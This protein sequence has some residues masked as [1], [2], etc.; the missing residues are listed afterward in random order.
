MRE[1]QGYIAGIYGAFYMVYI[2]ELWEEE[3]REESL[4]RAKVRGKLRISYQVAYKV[5]EKFFKEHLLAVGDQIKVQLLVSSHEEEKEIEG[6]I[7]YLFPRKNVF[8]RC[9]QTKIQNIAADIDRVLVLGCIRNPVFSLGFLDR[10]LVDAEAIGVEVGILVN[11]MDL[12]QEEEEEKE[13]LRKLSYYEKIGYPVFYE[14]VLYEVSS[15]LRSFLEKGVTLFVGQ[16]GVGKST[17]LNSLVGKSIQATQEVSSHGKGRHTTTNPILYPYSKEAL[18]ID[19]PGVREFGLM[20]REKEE[21]A[22]YFRDFPEGSCKY[23]DC[24]HQEEPGCLVKEK[25]EKGEIPSWRYHSY[26]DI[27]QSLEEKFKPRRGDYWHNLR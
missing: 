27:L 17:L 23:R 14:K 2:P 19:V 6:Y 22:R 18:F 26:I 24:L 20:H 11:K 7:S 21:I 15:S 3:K 12:Y 9:Y 13:L 1:Y 25:V 8:R 4:Y 5:R 16:S 10:V